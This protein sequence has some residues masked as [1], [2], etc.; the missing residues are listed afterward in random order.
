MGP[1]SAVGALWVQLTDTT[2]TFSFSGLVVASVVYSF[3]F[4]V[5]PFADRALD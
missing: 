3:P 1:A 4:A 5:Q 2:L